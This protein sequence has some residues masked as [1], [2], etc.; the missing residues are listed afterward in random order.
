[1]PQWIRDANILYPYHGDGKKRFDY[2]YQKS[3]DFFKVEHSE[4]NRMFVSD[5]IDEILD[6]DKIE[7]IIRDTQEIEPKKE[8]C[9]EKKE[10]ETIEGSHDLCPDGK[11]DQSAE[12]SARYVPW[13]D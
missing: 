12:R 4:L 5:C 10:D 3:L 7:K 2:V 9:Y 8:F 6:A 11:E 1:M 13:R